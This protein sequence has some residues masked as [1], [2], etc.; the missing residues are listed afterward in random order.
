MA[1]YK[2]EWSNKSRIDLMD[3]LEF[4]IQQNGNKNYSRKLNTKINKSIMYISKNPF[5]GLQS[6]INSVRAFV[7]GDYEI[8]YELIDSTI[9]VVMIWDCRRNPED[10]RI[11]SRLHK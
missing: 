7:T 10:R 2:V 5:I 4:Y 1:K 11:T 6:D 9:L 3:I 8:I